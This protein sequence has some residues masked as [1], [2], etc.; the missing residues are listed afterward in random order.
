[1]TEVEGVDLFYS[2]FGGS[3]TTRRLPSGRTCYN[4]VIGGQ[5][6]LDFYDIIYPYVRVKESQVR[7]ARQYPIGVR[8]PGNRP[9]INKR[10]ETRE[11][12]RQDI[13]V[14]RKP[15]S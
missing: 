8:G 14:F 15:V 5:A 10:F 3:I 7:V 12:L 11:N 6:A 2:M 1:M 13:I 9:D 4:W